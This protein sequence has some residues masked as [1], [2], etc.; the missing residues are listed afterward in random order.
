M[1][2]LLHLRYVTLCKAV[3]HLFILSL[4]LTVS[5]PS[6]ALEELAIITKTCRALLEKV[7]ALEIQSAY[8]LYFLFILF[9]K[10]I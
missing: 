9:L 4:K 3:Y 7:D 6:F 1:H 5:A 2:V 10:V 8:Y